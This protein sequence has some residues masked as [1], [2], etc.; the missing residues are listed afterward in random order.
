MMGHLMKNYGHMTLEDMRDKEQDLIVMCTDP[1]SSVGK[2]FST[3]D[4]FR[5]LYILTEQSKYDI[6]ITD[7]SYMI[8]INLE[9][10]ANLIIQS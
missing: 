10:P 3:I 5:N 6:Q 8:L 9:L 7:I 2:V 4:K 1:S